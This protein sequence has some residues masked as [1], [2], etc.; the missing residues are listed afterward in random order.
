MPSL[1]QPL[2]VAALNAARRVRRDHNPAMLST[3]LFSQGACVVRAIAHHVGVLDQ[4]QQVRGERDLVRLSLAQRE[5]D[6]I[7]DGIDD[8]VDFGRRTSP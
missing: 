5:A 6:G 1:V 7:A 4:R 3:E 2:V 8:G